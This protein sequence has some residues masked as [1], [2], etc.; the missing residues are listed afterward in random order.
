MSML[1]RDRV[2]RHANTRSFPASSA[3]HSSGL[4]YGASRRPGRLEGPAGVHS[5]DPSPTMLVPEAT[6]DVISWRVS[7]ERPAV[8]VAGRL[9]ARPAVRG[10]PQAEPFAASARAGPN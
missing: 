6:T 9:S 10:G 4:R 3:S 5:N 1:R 7:R 2:P 8:E